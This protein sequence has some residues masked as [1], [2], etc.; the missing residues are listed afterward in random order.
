MDAIMRERSGICQENFALMP[1]LH[2]ARKPL[3]VPHPKPYI[4]REKLPVEAK[5]VTL[6]AGFRCKDGV[7]LCADTEITMEG[8]LKYPESKIRV[9]SQL[10]HQPVFT[11]AGYANFA[12]MFISKLSRRVAL[13]EKEGQSI[14]GAVEEESLLIHRT[15]AGEECERNTVLLMSLWGAP[16]GP[17]LL[18]EIREGVVNPVKQSCQGTG[19]LVTRAMITELFA[20]DMSI[21]E[22]ALLAV[23]LLAEAKT[24]GAGVGQE[25][26]IL[27]LDDAGWWTPFPDDPFYTDM[28]EIEGDYIRLK[29]F[30]KPIILAYSNVG[31]NE[32]QFEEIVGAFGKCAANWRARR[33]GAYRS[34]V[35]QDLERQAQ[36]WEEELQDEGPA[37]GAQ[38]DPDTEG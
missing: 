11:F 31:V 15:F 3:P 9:Y 12:G 38:F 16:K 26:Q 32:E 2:P 22:T 18:Y 1:P 33:I 30:L 4:R 36:E 21:R 7:V 6:A 35:E 20:L 24:Y 14:L 28:K 25:S 34:L 5:S 8:W 23:Y 10:K 13:A 29:K 17:R 37:E 27:L 19:V